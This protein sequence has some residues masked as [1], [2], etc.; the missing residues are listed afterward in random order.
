MNAYVLRHDC[1][2]LSC[3]PPHYRS[4]PALSG[5]TGRFR[6]DLPADPD[7]QYLEIEAK[8][9]RAIDLELGRTGGLLEGPE[10]APGTPGA[11]DF[12]IGGDRGGWREEGHRPGVA[13]EARGWGRGQGGRGDAGGTGEGDGVRLH[14]WDGD[15][16]E[17]AEDD[18]EGA[19]S[20]H[21]R[22]R[23]GGGRGNSMGVSGWPRGPVEGTS[24]AEGGAAE[25]GRPGAAAWG[26]LGGTGVV[27]PRAPSAGGSRAS[28]DAVQA[29]GGRR[30]E[31][32]ASLAPTGGPKR[33]GHPSAPPAPAQPP[34]GWGADY[35]F[36]FV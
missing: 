5:D 8:L 32:D 7:R 4:L 25:V 26:S 18:L 12:G 34:P 35:A 15:G 22:W 2:V 6:G 21:K 36:D 33:P 27:T 23:G 13:E 10:V 9:L 1:P 31:H 29:G 20:P 24:N 14:R 16:G 3:E 17:E 30:E 11:G 19:H 28:R